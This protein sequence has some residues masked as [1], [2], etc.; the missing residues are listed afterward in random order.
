MNDAF[1][2]QIRLKTSFACTIS[3]PNKHYVIF[4]REFSFCLSMISAYIFT[5]R[6]RNFKELLGDHHDVCIKNQ[7]ATVATR[8]YRKFTLCTCQCVP[9]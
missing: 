2:N 3:F 1:L 9:S 5:C 4:S 7:S 8:G 6:N